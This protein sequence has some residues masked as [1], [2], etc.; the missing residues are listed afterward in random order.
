MFKEI[1]PFEPFIN[2]ILFFKYKETSEGIKIFVL[3]IF[4]ILN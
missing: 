2:K 4:F 1:T 3:K